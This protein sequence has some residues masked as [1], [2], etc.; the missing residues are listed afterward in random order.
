VKKRSKGNLQSLPETSVP[1]V[2]FDRAQRAISKKRDRHVRT[3]F[4]VMGTTDVGVVVEHGEILGKTHSEKLRVR[5]HNEIPYEEAF[6]LAY[7][8]ND[9][10]N[11]HDPD[12][13]D[14]YFE[15]YSGS[16][17]ERVK[18]ISEELERQPP[19]AVPE[20]SAVSEQS[21]MK[22]VH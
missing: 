22:T 17:V 3:Y 7:H 18:A 14:E 13:F 9:A 16:S 12:K 20:Q 6:L 21:P 4:R 15:M 10:I 8:L 1:S 5:Y 19:E 11:Q 2:D